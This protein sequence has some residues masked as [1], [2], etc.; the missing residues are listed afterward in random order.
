MLYIF[1]K[2]FFLNIN[3]FQCFL[4]M[5]IIGTGTMLPPAPGYV[6][7]VEFLGV[8]ALSFLGVNKDQAFGYIVTLHVFQILTI[9]FWGI[10]GLITEKITFSELIHIEK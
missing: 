4:V 3:I 10:H 2:A 8:T 7:T 1:S 5:I 6:G 9:F